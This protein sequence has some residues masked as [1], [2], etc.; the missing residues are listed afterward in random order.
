LWA[1]KEKWSKKGLLNRPA[2]G[3]GV[4]FWAVGKQACGTLEKKTQ[5]GK[6]G[7][8]DNTAN[9]KKGPNNNVER[10]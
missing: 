2:R 6:G 4:G 10:L 8:I 3:T 7:E 1:R 5:K 9:G